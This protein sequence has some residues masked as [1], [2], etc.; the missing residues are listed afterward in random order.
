MLSDH[1]ASVI[2]SL[3]MGVLTVTIYI[4]IERETH[5]QQTASVSG[6]I[7]VFLFKAH[8]NQLN[9]PVCQM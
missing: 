1:R 6:S 7:C 4:Y 9:D 3:K 2:M 8:N 5:T